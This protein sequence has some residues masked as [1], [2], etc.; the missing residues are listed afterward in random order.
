[1]KKTRKIFGFA[2]CGLMMCS[3]MK[4]VSALTNY[5]VDKWQKTMPTSEGVLE[6][7]KGYAAGSAEQEGSSNKITIKGNSYK[8]NKE[9]S[10]D[11]WG[12]YNVGPYVEG[13]IDTVAKGIHEELQIGL[14]PAKIAHQEFF[15]ISFSLKDNTKTPTTPSDTTHTPEDYVNEVN[16]ITENVSGEIYIGI[17]NINISGGVW[18]TPIAKVKEAGIYTYSWEITKEGKFIFTVKN[19]DGQVIGKSEELDID[20][21]FNGPDVKE[22]SE[23]GADKVAVRWIWFCN[24]QVANGVEVYSNT[25]VIVAQEVVGENITTPAETADTLKEELNVTKDEELKEFIETH[26]V[27]VELESKPVEKESIDEAVVKDFESAIE[28]ATLTD[29]FNL[30]IVVKAD[31]EPD[32]YLRELTKP[33]TLSVKL[34]ELPEV[35]EGYKRNYYILREHNGKVEKLETKL[36]EDGKSLTFASDKFS[37]YV[38]AYVD[39]V[40]PSNPQTGDN[41]LTY[42]FVG[43][44]S[45]LVLGFGVKKLSKNN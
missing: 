17:Q 11:K 30:D 12:A 16:I 6:G 35:K 5:K 27:T 44:I 20:D 41:I 43:L 25:D 8:G 4:P 3:F 22:I 1:M 37:R 24:V 45:I 26:D 36:S 39:E 18:Q 15:E 13:G 2:I 40:V 33:I 19:S 29:F 21:T 9:T 32:H 14:D 10:P 31:G 23:V 7:G 38:I 42:V 34:P 28:N